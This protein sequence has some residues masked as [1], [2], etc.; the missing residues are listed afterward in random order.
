[1]TNEKGKNSMSTL[2][3]PTAN[4]DPQA[5]R[6]P[7]LAIMGEFSVGKSTLTNLLIGSNPLPV[8]VTA[9]HLPPVWMSYGDDAPYR[10]DLDGNV[11]PIDIEELD[12]I[13]LEETAVIRMFLKSD[14][15]E[16][17]DL[18]DMPGISDPNMSAEVW[19]R[20]LHN[21]DGVLWCTNA[22]QAWRQSEA[23]VWN[24]VPQAFFE[25]SMLLITRFEKL[26][27]EADRQKVIKRVR[28]ETQGKFSGLFPIS[29]T[30]AIQGQED[31]D[32]WE[33]S[34]AENFTQC[35]VDLTHNLSKSLSSS[36]TSSLAPTLLAAQH[37]GVKPASTQIPV[38]EAPLAP[39]DS[40]PKVLRLDIAAQKKDPSVATVVPVRVRAVP[41]PDR[42]TPRPV[43]NDASTTPS[44]R[45]ESDLTGS[46]QPTVKQDG[47]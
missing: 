21:A 35:L 42:I 34:G 46:V 3:A 38:A 15:L 29:L 16:L 13:P 11:I 5:P 14:V 43:R 25:T 17:C 10:E 33:L 39:N 19:Q 37:T 40:E 7:R 24:T 44:R 28:R 22:T 31:R 4:S 27:T 41:N 23:A 18:I 36:T 6:K 1:L 12:R 8:R 2:E 45:Q 32:L 26:L 30:E 47:L 9:T 20:I